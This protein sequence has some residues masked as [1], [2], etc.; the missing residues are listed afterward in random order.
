MVRSN[1]L[2]T[3]IPGSRVAPLA[4][5]MVLALYAGATH[6]GNG[7][8]VTTPAALVQP[9]LVTPKAL[10][11]AMLAVGVA[12][13]RLVAA[14]ERGVIL[15]SDDAGKSWRQAAVPVS[16]SLTALQFVD[17]RNGWAVG[18]QGVVLHTTDGGAT[19]KKQLDGIQAAALVLSDA[20]ASFGPERDK[21]VA[22]A[23][24]LVDD[25]PDKP[26]LDLYFDSP[27]SGYVLGAYNMM[28]RTVDGGATWQPWQSRVANPKGLHLY[29][30]RGT[31][32]AIYLAGEQ[33]LL[34][35]STDKGDSFKALP[36]PY[37]GSY[38]G[39]LSA[40]GG[41]LLAYGLRGNAFRS[42]DQGAT[43]SQVATGV[44]A[45]LAAGTVTSDGAVVLVSQGGDVLVSRDDGRTFV[46]QPGTA[47]PLAAVAQAGDGTLVVAGLRGVRRIP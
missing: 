25:G 13:A 9:A 11:A 30:M 19:W 45:S 4:A 1:P 2:F 3:R 40:R 42:T 27:T 41:V 31:G 43:W 37:K 29:G 23:Q 20:S 15:Y 28:F 24:R 22:D 39:L 46:P 26:F 8:K 17:S 21:A 32:N 36:T 44:Q 16:V 12:G 5:A 38:F 7:A 18:H 6:G 14:G 10:Q 47:L 33:G 35:R 34:L